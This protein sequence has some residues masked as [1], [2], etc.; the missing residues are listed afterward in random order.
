MTTPSPSPFA[1][2]RS[3]ERFFTEEDVT[4]ADDDDDD[5]DDEDP[6]M[7]SE[8]V[9]YCGISRGNV[10]KTTSSTNL[11]L[12][13]DGWEHAV[14][15]TVVGPMPPAAGRAPI[16]MSHMV[17]VKFAGNKGAVACEVALLSREWPAPQ[18]NGYKLKE[19]VYYCQKNSKPNPDDKIAY[20]TRGEVAGCGS[21]H[22]RTL[23]QI[24]FDGNDHTL[25]CTAAELRRK[26]PPAPSS[27]SSVDEGLMAELTA[28]FDAI[29]TNGNGTIERAEL[30]AHMRK[31]GLAEKWVEQLFKDLDVDNDGAITRDE[32]QRGFGL[33]QKVQV[34]ATESLT[35]SARP[36]DLAALVAGDGMDAD[37]DGF[38]ICTVTSRAYHL[39]RRLGTLWGNLEKGRLV[40]D[41]LHTHRT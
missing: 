15:G 30:E 37:G 20:G 12:A 34:R 36:G 5:D 38:C 3:R 10:L 9:Y 17:M 39:E 19:T 13:G 6:L 11:S 16:P 41:V 22:V 2:A 40:V 31:E 8:K 25:G 4:A 29:D 7:P 18:M 21:G 23:L 33:Y 14:Q 24:R 27:S 28:T 35:L 1:R 26:A 32:F